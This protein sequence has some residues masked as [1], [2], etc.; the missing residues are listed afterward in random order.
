MAPSLFPLQGARPSTPPR[1]RQLRGSLRLPVSAALPALPVP[2]HRARLGSLGAAPG[3]G[4]HCTPGVCP[5]CCCLSLAGLR[6]AGCWCCSRHLRATSL[7]LKPLRTRPSPRA[8]PSPH[9]HPSL[10]PTRA[11]AE[12]QINGRDVIWACSLAVSGP[13]APRTPEV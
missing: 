12:R 3:Q 4:P 9:T 7:G 2:Q 5:A 1:C 8:H 11:S 6:A 10:H 13:R